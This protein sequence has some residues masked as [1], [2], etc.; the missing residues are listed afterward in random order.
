RADILIIGG[1]VAA[2]F[3]ATSRTGLGGPI[4]LAIATAFV[5]DAKATA[6]I[7]IAPLFAI[8]LQQRGWR[9][10]ALVLL[11]AGSLASLPFFLPNVS[12]SQYLRWLRSATGHP[13][14]LFDLRSTLRTLPILLAPGLLVVGPTPWRDPQVVAWLRKNWLLALS[15]PACL[16]L[17]VLAST[18]IGAG[19]HHVL[20]FVPLLA[21]V[22]LQLYLVSSQTFAARFPWLMRYAVACLGIVAVVRAGG[23]L[24]E[25]RGGNA[26]IAAAS[27]VRDEVR[28][29]LTRYPGRK[30]A[31]GYGE[32]KEPLTYF[33]PELVFATDAYLVDEIAL[34]DMSMDGMPIPPSTVAAIESCNVAIWLIPKDQRP[35]LVP[36]SF[37]ETYAHLVPPVPLFS[38]KF[39]EAFDRHYQ[40]RGS[41]PHFDLWSCDNR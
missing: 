24:L 29:V 15:L 39:R 32:R 30:V 20:P 23:G 35:F 36:S 37:S 25:L 8:F 19:S 4:A 38:A 7:Y 31:M 27:A 18:R 9:L 34:S 33:R 6:F 5:L 13:S 1:T 3:G 40:R 10:T 21:Y 41:T 14:T 28:S 2:L 16:G 17:A 26:S 12:L 22:Y 11:G